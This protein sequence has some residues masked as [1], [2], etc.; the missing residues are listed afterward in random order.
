[1]FQPRELL[2]KESVLWLI[3]LKRHSPACRGE[4]IL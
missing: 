3:V 2:F 1:M 4:G